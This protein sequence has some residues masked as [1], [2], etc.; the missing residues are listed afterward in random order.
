M[1]KHGTGSFPAKVPSHGSIIWNNS[2]NLQYKND[3]QR[4][5]CSA[6]WYI[7]GNRF[8]EVFQHCIFVMLDSIIRE[9]TAGE[10]VLVIEAGR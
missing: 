10:G 2:N 4:N 5:W 7:R 6:A 8:G 3:Y 1:C 9:D